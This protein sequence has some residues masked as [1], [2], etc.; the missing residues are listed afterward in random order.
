[1]NTPRIMYKGDTI[2]FNGFSN[3]HPDQKIC[4]KIFDINKVIISTSIPEE[5]SLLECHNL[6]TLKNNRYFDKNLVFMLKC[7]GVMSGTG[8]IYCENAYIADL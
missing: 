3:I 6:I 8:F 4:I 7:S 2:I 5:E 1:M